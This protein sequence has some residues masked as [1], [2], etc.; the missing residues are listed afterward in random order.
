LEGLL[1][2]P[3]PAVMSIWHLQVGTHR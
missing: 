3:P 1:Y 2:G